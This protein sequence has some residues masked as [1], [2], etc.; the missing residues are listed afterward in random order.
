MIVKKL[1]RTELSY[2]GDNSPIIIHNDPMRKHM[3]DKLIIFLK[4]DLTPNQPVINKNKSTPHTAI[5][6]SIGNTPPLRD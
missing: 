6:L 3:I 4:T 2:T 5:E 1:L